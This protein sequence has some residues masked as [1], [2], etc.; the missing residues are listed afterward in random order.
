VNTGLILAAHSQAE[1]AGVLAHEAAHSVLSHGLQSVFREDLIAQMGSQVPLGDFV[2]EMLSL[3]YSRQQ[4]RQADILGT[5]VLATAG[6]AADGLRN[7]METL[8]EKGEPDQIEYF[9]THPAASTRVE[10]LEALI[11]QN[12]YN[13]YALEGVDRHSEIQAMV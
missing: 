3:Q 9:S 10:Y 7:F 11:Q 6:Y 12:G 1:L 4:E 5:R 8:Y 2:G 13:R